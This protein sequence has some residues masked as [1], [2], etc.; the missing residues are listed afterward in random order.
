ILAETVLSSQEDEWLPLSARIG[1]AY[2][3]GI[4]FFA[5]ATKF[6]SRRSAWILG[7]VLWV[8]YVGSRSR[9]Q[10]FARRV[11]ERWRSYCTALGGLFLLFNLF[12]LP[13]HLTLTYGPFTEG[14]GD[15]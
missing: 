8:L 5:A 7:L 6:L 15:V 14:G 2:I 9:W 13:L 1:L 4:V 11:R 12:F 3:L 10:A